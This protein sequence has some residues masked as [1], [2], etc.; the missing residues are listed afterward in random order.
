MSIIPQNNNAIREI[1]ENPR[2]LKIF[3]MKRSLLGDLIPS[4]IIFIS[5][6]ILVFLGIYGTP[7]FRDFAIIFDGGYRIFIGMLPF[8]DFALF[9]IPVTFYLQAFF[10]KIFGP[11]LIAMGFYSIALS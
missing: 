9:P 5:I 3:K 1:E 2:F 4:I 6:S 8:R 11:N 10:N 7:F